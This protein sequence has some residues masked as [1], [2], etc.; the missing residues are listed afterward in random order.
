MK[1]GEKEMLENLD[2]EKRN[3]KTTELDRFS[4]GELLQTMNEEDATI[5]LAIRDALREISEVV[6]KCLSTIE[7]RGKVYYVGAGTSGRLAIID[8]VEL[9]PTFNA[10]SDLFIPIMAG[11]TEAAF[12]A[13]EGSEDQESLGEKEIV[14]RK[15]R[16]IDLIIGVTASGRTPFVRGALKKGKEI[17]CPTA[18]I[19]NVQR[20]EIASLADTVIK[21]VT[22]P[23]VLT[24]STRLKAGTAQKMVLNMISTAT[25][26]KSGKVFQNLMI[27][28]VVL[29]EKLRERAIKIVME[30]TGESAER[31]QSEL[32]KSNWKAKQAI[33]QI[34]N[35]ISPNE[36]Q[37]ALE[38]HGGFLRRAMKEKEK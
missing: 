21:V 14:D 4:I 30:S 11:G 33:L 29:N 8:A 7:N 27:D 34:I 25:M 15:V 12:K 1:E 9:I 37:E 26:V 6:S 23:E 16:K 17:G 38:R 24:G 28:V 22:G 32:I 2:T 5:P 36:A 10:P 18:L 20:P 31:S 35:D 3:P 13:V 19:C